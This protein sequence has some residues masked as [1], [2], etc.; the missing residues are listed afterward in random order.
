[1]E[2]MVRL[3]NVETGEVA[4]QIEAQVQ[5][6]EYGMRVTKTV[7]GLAFSPDGKTLAACG[8][9][10]T[11][12]LWS[13]ETG[14]KL[15]E[16]KDID[17]IMDLAWTPNGN[18][19]FAGGQSM[20]TMWNAQTGEKIRALEGGSR[21]LAIACSRDGKLMASAGGDDNV[22]IWDLATGKLLRTC[23]P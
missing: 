2:G 23:A 21:V 12:T 13:V 19:I 18:G 3:W 6:N 9:H 4:R 8:G 16:M 17:T 20:L 7:Y 11:V 22:K 1:M 15:R 14:E 10:K 5:E